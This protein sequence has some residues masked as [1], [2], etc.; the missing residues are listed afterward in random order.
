MSRYD[1]DGGGRFGIEPHYYDLLVSTS[2][3]DHV[4]TKT[5]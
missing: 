4:L 5:L 3:T 1:W 2:V